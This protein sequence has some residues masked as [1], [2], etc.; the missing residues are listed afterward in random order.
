[1]WL[2]EV[3]D[4]YYTEWHISLDNNFNVAYSTIFPLIVVD[5]SPSEVNDVSFGRRVP[6]AG[7]S[8]TYVF[9]LYLYSKINL[10]VGEDYNRDIQILTR[11]IIDWFTTKHQNQ[12]E[13]SEHNIWSVMV[14]GGRESEPNIRD[15]AR[16]IL[17]IE[18]EVLR[19]DGQ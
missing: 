13:M 8:V 15:V 10:V 6:F 9:T 5:F 7:A 3:L 1:M 19:E 4:E 11:R 14:I 17:T 16:M 2:E 18:I 12:T